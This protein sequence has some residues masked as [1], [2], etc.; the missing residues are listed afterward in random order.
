MTVRS[1]GCSQPVAETAYRRVQCRMKMLN[2]LALAFL[3]QVLM[4]AS[5]YQARAQA[6][7]DPGH[8]SS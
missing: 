8:G 7:K 1:L 6:E 5:T 3:A 2:F 4:P